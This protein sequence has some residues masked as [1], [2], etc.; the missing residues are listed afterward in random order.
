L[1]GGFISSL[2]E[3]SSSRWVVAAGEKHIAAVV[4]TQKAIDAYLYSTISISLPKQPSPWFYET[5]SHYATLDGLEFEMLTRL[6]LN[7]WRSSCL[8]LVLRVYVI[9]PG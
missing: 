2:R 4:K 1:K 5:G 3:Y 7:S 6:A 9:T 8:Y